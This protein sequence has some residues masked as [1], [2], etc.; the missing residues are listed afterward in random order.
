MFQTSSVQLVLI[1]SVLQREAALFAPP[2]RHLRQ[3]LIHAIESKPSSTAAK[4]PPTA[5][6]DASA[7]H[8]S[9]PFEAHGVEELALEATKEHVIKMC[10]WRQAA[11]QAIQ[12]YFFIPVIVRICMKARVPLTNLFVWLQKKHSSEV[13]RRRRKAAFPSCHAS[14]VQSRCGGC[15][16]RGVDEVSG[17][18]G[19]VGICSREGRPDSASERLTS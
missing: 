14:P 16:A 17:V 8:A 4:P 3:C 5:L 7:S 15:R 6:M 9:H 11:A 19:R 2:F 1:F 18:G 13:H 12:D 10:K